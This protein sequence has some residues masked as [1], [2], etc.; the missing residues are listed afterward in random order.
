MHDTAIVVAFFSPADYKLPKSHFV[1]TM[2]RLRAEKADVVVVQHI[3]PWQQPLPVPSEF[4]SRWHMSTSVMFY[5]ENLWNIGA[6][7]TESSK[8]IFIDADL[9]FE[10]DDWLGKTESALDR[11]DVAQPFETCL[12]LDRAGSAIGN[13]KHSAAKAICEN[14]PWSAETCH[15]GFGWAFNRKAFDAVGGF[16]DLNAAG[17][18][19]TALT[20]ALTKNI[21]ANNLYRWFQTKQDSSNSW[22]EYRARVQAAEV[23]VGFAEGVTV[24][25]LWHGDSAN[26]NYVS[27]DKLFVRKEDGEHPIH[28]RD[29]GL[30]VWDDP[31]TDNAGPLEYFRSRMEDG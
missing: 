31:D 2:K 17:S 13:K 25:H 28:R 19:D 20:L 11:F 1:E 16:F 22:K 10:P 9:I 5:K 24:K 3:L 7:L 27:R 6:T 29:D 23:S 12:W 15:A 8:L 26:R 21:E 30:L 4:T 18:G 14:I